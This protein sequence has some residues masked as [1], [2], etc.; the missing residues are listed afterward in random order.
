LC[1]GLRGSASAATPIPAFRDDGVAVAGVTDRYDAL[2]T[3]LAQRESA[4]GARFY[5]CIVARSDP[6]DRSGAEYAPSAIPFV[7]DVFEAWGANVD[8]ERGIVI[9]MALENRGIAVKP[10]SAWTRLGFERHAVTEV[11]DASSF[12]EYARAGDYGGAILA[13][14]DAID[15]ELLRRQA[16]VAGARERAVALVATLRERLAAAIERLDAAPF[17]DTD[18]RQDVSGLSLRIESSRES[19]EVDRVGEAL[20]ELE[21][22][23]GDLGAFERRLTSTIAR[24]RFVRQTL[25][26]ILAIAV[27][28]IAVALALVFL[29]HAR[30]VRRR[31]EDA[32]RAFDGA[33]T[34]AAQHLDALAD[35]HALLFGAGELSEQFSGRTLERVRHAAA[36]VDE[37]FL[38]FAAAERVIAAA[39]AALDGR[40]HPFAVAGSREALRL[41]TEQSVEVGKEASTERRLLVP[42][43]RTLTVPAGELL[44][45]M[46]AIYAEVCTSADALTRTMHEVSERLKKAAATHSGTL[47][48]LA[49]LASQGFRSA[50]L[51]ARQGAIDA[52]LEQVFAQS[53]TDAIGASEAARALEGDIATLADDVGRTERTL[54]LIETDIAPL[55]A[56]HPARIAR[57]RET[58]L[59]LA[60]P[61]FEP[62][63]MLAAAQGGATAARAAALRGDVELAWREAERARDQLA[64]LGGLV[65]ASL[66]V[67]AALSERTAQARARAV[68]LR[69]RVPERRARLAA[70]RVEHA[71]S[72]LVPALDNI[73]EAEAA[74]SH[75]ETAV[76]DAERAGAPS[77]Q[78]YLAA[79]ERLR[80]ATAALDAIDALFDEI[81]GKAEHLA[82]Q[83]QIAESA[84]AAAIDD[85]GAARDIALLDA[86]V[87]SA[88]CLLGIDSLGV[89]LDAV[90]AAHHGV[91]PDWIWKCA[92]ASGLRDR[93]AALLEDARAQLESYRSVTATYPKLAELADVVARLLA[94]SEDDRPAANQAYADAARTRDGIARALAR[95]GD[96]GAADAEPR[97][98]DAELCWER[99]LAETGVLRDLLQRARALARADFGAAAL[100]RKLVAEATSGVRAASGYYGMG[101]SANVANAESAMARARQALLARDYEAAQR[102]AT[103]ATTQA[104]RAVVEARALAAR[105]R[106]AARRATAPASRTATAGSFPSSSRGGS[107]RGGGSS[108]GTSSGGSSYRSGAGGSSW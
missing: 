8:V 41:L 39:R 85:Y 34:H 100:A 52:R 23:H 89:E 69:Q 68:Q 36:K 1:V 25:P 47:A 106:V 72:A 103:D 29:A 5:V 30:R 10:G 97:Q 95:A 82:E 54:A 73:E 12:G 14:A 96:S 3:A 24:E 35:D 53:H 9:V 65:G 77:E 84:L 66:E 49:R 93:A 20:R 101:I 38:R 56:E 16:R 107:S 43:E 50:A 51:Y 87:R 105:Q 102:C 59:R 60:E 55:L 108:F 40:R 48:I 42:L 99:V 27:L 76:D 22:L 98:A 57:H 74:L 46:D 75:A 6:Y 67:R 2:R 92:K 15:A 90:R 32:M 26:W 86:A 11:I 13:L 80:R 78:R 31:A 61:G 44:P 62:E 88:T 17:D 28:A 18:L 45:S 63:A 81:D 7:D 21:T 33:L 4:T 64:E 71:D 83:R 104:E 70:L 37:L 79:R 58:G 91:R 19:L 94:E